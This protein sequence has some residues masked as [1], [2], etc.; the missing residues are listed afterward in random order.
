M[1][2]HAWR[3]GRQVLILV[4]A[5]WLQLVCLV[6]L[7]QSGTR[8]RRSRFVQCSPDW[9]VCR[10]LLLLHLHGF[11]VNLAAGRGL[12]LVFSDLEL[13][14]AFEDLDPMKAHFDAKVILQVHFSDVLNNLPIDSDFL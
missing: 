8:L 13:L 2:R 6:R 9:L 1:L 4:T 5:R 7:R 11:G 14:D 10:F 3:R 12:A